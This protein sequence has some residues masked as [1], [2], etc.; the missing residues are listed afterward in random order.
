M[1]ENSGSFNFCF[2]LLIKFLRHAE[3]GLANIMSAT[4]FMSR[5]LC[6]IPCPI[7]SQFLWMTN[8]LNNSTFLYHAIFLC[9]ICMGPSRFAWIVIC[10]KTNFTSYIREQLTCGVFHFWG[11]FWGIYLVSRNTLWS[12]N[13][14]LK[15]CDFTVLH[16]GFL[17]VSVVVLV[18][19]CCVLLSFYVVVS[20]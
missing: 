7:N 17:Y 5:K 14:G 2:I 16:N 15:K 11:K 3:T 6:C 9:V 10:G 20:C 8:S 12:G 4:L 19:V 1:R 18:S 13:C